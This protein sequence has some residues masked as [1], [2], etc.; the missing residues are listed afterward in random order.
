MH[1]PNGTRTLDMH[2]LNNKLTR[3]YLC[4]K[5]DLRDGLPVVPL[6]SSFAGSTALG[7]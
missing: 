6:G 4:V 7:A 5:R 3:M 1:M 2:M